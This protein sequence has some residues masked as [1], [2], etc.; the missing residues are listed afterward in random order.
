MLQYTYI[1]NNIRAKWDA[2]EDLKQD[3]L[4]QQL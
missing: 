3:S 2:D 4:V 1:N